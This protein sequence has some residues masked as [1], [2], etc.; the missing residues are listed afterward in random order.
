MLMVGSRD[1][2]KIHA[3][4][5]C[6]PTKRIH[7]FVKWWQTFHSYIKSY[8]NSNNNVL[9]RWNRMEWNEMEISTSV[10]WVHWACHDRFIIFAPHQIFRS[11]FPLINT[12]FS[13]YCVNLW[14]LFSASSCMVHICW[15]GQP[16][17]VLVHVWVCTTSKKCKNSSLVAG[18]TCLWNANTHTHTSGQNM[19]HF[20]CVLEGQNRE[21]LFAKPMQKKCHWC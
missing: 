5:K 4:D 9:G 3:I 21:H 18:A 8:N 11:M 20:N 16:L 2:P 12:T 13:F 17:E 14:V 19:I 6:T 1:C 15:N 7:I 10:P